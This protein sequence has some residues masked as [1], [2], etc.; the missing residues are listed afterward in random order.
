MRHMVRASEAG[1]RLWFGERALLRTSDRV[2]GWLAGLTGVGILAMM[3]LTVADVARREVIG[4]GIPG[5]LEYAE[6][7]LVCVA[8]GGMALAEVDR[9]HVRTDLVTSRLPSR[10]A[11]LLRL[12]GSVVMLVTLAWMTWL[13][14]QGALDSIR[15]NE[16]RIG[17]AAVP[18]WPARVAI[19]VG[20][21]ALT[22]TVL[23]KLIRSLRGDRA[24]EQP[25]SHE[26][27]V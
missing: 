22:L 2:S 12:V 7:G 11:S 8:F 23:A 27:A 5:S 24:D 21:A 17:L 15:E 1:R 3:V 14:A 16:Q 6:V 25:P 9:A 18:I 10:L 26:S 19:A 20:L 4:R 13:T